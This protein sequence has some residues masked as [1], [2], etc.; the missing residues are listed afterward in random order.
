MVRRSAVIEEPLAAFVHRSFSDDPELIPCGTAT[1]LAWSDVRK[2]SVEQQSSAALWI[3]SR[4]EV[5]SSG[6]AELLLQIDPQA[7]A[8]VNT[9]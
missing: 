1:E 2:L 4:L 5:F 6:H 9:A 3:F 8:Q 7:Q